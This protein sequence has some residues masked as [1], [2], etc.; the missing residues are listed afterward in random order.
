M[1]PLSWVIRDK[2]I[3]G[4]ILSNLANTETDILKDLGKDF[5]DKPIDSFNKKYIRG[6]GSKIKLT[7]IDI[8]DILKVIRSLEHREI[9]LKGTLPKLLMKKED[10]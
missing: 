10:F 3:C 1:V 6:K 8:K 5:L 7:K 9:L 4:R 2:P